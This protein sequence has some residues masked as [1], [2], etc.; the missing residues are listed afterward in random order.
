MRTSGL[1]MYQLVKHCCTGVSVILFS[2][3]IIYLPMVSQSL[4]G[5]TSVLLP[6]SFFGAIVFSLLAFLLWVGDPHTP[7]TTKKQ[8]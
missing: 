6:A 8:G 7:R 5:F 4:T 3:F 1:S 2:L